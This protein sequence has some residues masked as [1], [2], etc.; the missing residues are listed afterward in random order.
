METKKF[1]CF[2][3]STDTIKL[4]IGYCLGEKPCVLYAETRPLPEGLL[5]RGVIKNEGALVEEF[6]KFTFF[7]NEALK[8][9]TTL[10]EICLVLPPVGLKIYLTNKLTSAS[11]GDKRITRVDV[12]NVIQQARNDTLPSGGEVVDII[13]TVFELSN[14]EKYAN[15]P[16]GK[17]SNFLSASLFIH[18]LPKASST[19]FVRL[20]NLSGF[21]VRKSSIAPYCQ[22]LLFAQDKTL[23]STYLLLDIGSRYTA[24]SLIGEHQPYRSHSFTLGGHDLS[25]FIASKFGISFAEAENIKKIYGYSERKSSY[26]PPLGKGIKEGSLLEEGFSQIDLNKAIEEFFDGYLNQ[27]QAAFR[28]LDDGKSGDLTHIDVVLTGGGSRLLGLDHFLS[29]SWPSHS[30]HR[31]SEAYVGANAKEYAACLGMLLAASHYSGTL[32]DNYHGV[33]QVSRASG[34]KEKKTERKNSAQEDSL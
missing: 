7:E 18:S 23:P 20:A 22:A 21:R 14:G 3:I 32:E 6:K 11:S 8:L 4:L 9:R 27:L 5:E 2:E 28:A 12:A 13:P 15:P 30:L 31:P 16:L 26:N 1:A 17:E 29:L 25:D 10:H 33:A 19:D 34:K 24:L